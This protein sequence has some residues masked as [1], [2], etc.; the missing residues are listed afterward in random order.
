MCDYQTIHGA[1]DAAAVRTARALHPVFF[2]EDSELLPLLR[3]PS[4]CVV[5]TER[6]DSTLW[7]TQTGTTRRKVPSQSLPP[8]PTKWR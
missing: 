7:G 6:I 4:D 5:I 1:A 3:R 2:E 8:P